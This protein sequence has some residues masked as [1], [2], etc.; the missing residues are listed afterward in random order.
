MSKLLL[1]ALVATLLGAGCSGEGDDAGNGAPTDEA[2]ETA[3]AQQTV[4]EQQPGVAED[5][6]DTGGPL[7]LEAASAVRTGDLLAVSLTTYE[8][9]DDA[10]VRGPR[11]DRPGPNRLTVLYDIDVD[12]RTDYT[13]KIIFADGALSLV[14]AG[15]GQAFEPVPVERPDDATAQFIH[16]V[17]VF[18]I[19]AGQAET[20]SEQDIQVAVESEAV[21]FKDRIPAEGWIL[22]AFAPSA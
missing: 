4:A 14:I 20:E 15:N 17:D 10:V 6:N 2:A 5:L 16:P 13:G 12:G 7:D 18:F 3:T 21:G 19:V 11:V 8:A 1:L 22:V 9:W